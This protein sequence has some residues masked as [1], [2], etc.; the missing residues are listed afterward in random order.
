MPPKKPKAEPITYGELKDQLAK[1]IEL[2]HGMAARIAPKD[3]A[4]IVPEEEITEL[5]E[6]YNEPSP[7]DFQPKVSRTGR[8]RISC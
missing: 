3:D 7:E 1:E 5:Q 6:E 4:A 2:L 8:A